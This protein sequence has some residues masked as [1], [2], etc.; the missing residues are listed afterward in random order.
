MTQFKGRAGTRPTNSQHL[1]THSKERKQ[2]GRGT[3]LLL[4]ALFCATSSLLQD[5]PCTGE[6]PQQKRGLLP[7]TFLSAGLV[8]QIPNARSLFPPLKPHTVWPSATLMKSVVLHHFT[9]AKTGEIDNV[10]NICILCVAIIT[11]KEGLSIPLSPGDCHQ[12]ACWTHHSSTNF[13]AYKPWIALLHPVSLLTVW[14]SWCFLQVS[15]IPKSIT[16]F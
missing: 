14:N 10:V 15:N 16:T 11:I 2:Q 12:P 9:P 7:S 4:I 1:P 13:K 5:K 6:A 3:N 8:G